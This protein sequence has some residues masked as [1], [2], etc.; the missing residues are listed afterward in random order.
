M[1]TNSSEYMKSYRRDLRRKLKSLFGSR[2]LACGATRQLQFA[3]V[4]PTELKGLGRGS[5]KR[6]YDVIH[7][8]DC[9]V[10]LCP[11]CHYDYD[12]VKI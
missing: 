11:S 7:N 1:T 3:H 2:C 6:L 9:Y 8:P 4:T 10:L 12:K 5:T